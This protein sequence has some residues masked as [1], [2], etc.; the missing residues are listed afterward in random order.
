VTATKKTT[1][2]DEPAIGEFEE[3]EVLE[4]GDPGAAAPAGG[5]V[6]GKRSLGVKEVIPFAWKLIG[7]SG[8][9]FL[10][11]FKA[12]ER[13][14]VEAQLERVRAEGYYVDLRVLEAN[15]PIKQPKGAVAVINH[16]SKDAGRK[17]SPKGFGVGA[18]P[19]RTRRT[20]PTAAA[21]AKSSG[22]A[23]KSS[24]AKSE[25]KVKKAAPKKAVKKKAKSRKK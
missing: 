23:K 2:E 17:G 6:G 20:R 21:A 1:P 15:A 11:L 12:I 16:A 22:A 10:T 3:P 5:A 19:A 14:D 4:E 24:H 9:L 8:D 13:E 25:T 18:V 7:R